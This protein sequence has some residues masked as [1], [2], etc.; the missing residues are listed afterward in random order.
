MPLIVIF[1]LI[2][3]LFV[4]SVGVKS[5]FSQLNNVKPV[6]S[7]KIS[8]SSRAEI[9]NML[10][11]IEKKNAPARKMGAMCYKVA[12][13]PEYQEYVCPVDGEKTVYGRKDSDTYWRIKNIVE[14]RRLA[15]YL[16]SLTNLV[17]FKLDEKLL[18]HKCSPD[19]KAEEK[20][21]FLITEYPDGRKYQYEKV[22]I[23][24]LRIL[25]GFF[26]HKIYYKT[27]NDAELPLKEES[28]R[29]KRILGVEVGNPAKK[30]KK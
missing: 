28:G 5:S 23:E 18:C 22:S 1:I 2:F 21:V 12:M 9:E 7:Q 25:A 4:V 17:K 19:I 14:M 30:D 8:N 24:D 13:P 26:E 20:H 27:D 6:T 3:S 10:K 15:E 29:I 16:N 11:Q